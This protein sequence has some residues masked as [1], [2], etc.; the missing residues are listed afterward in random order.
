MEHR[1]FYLEALLTP[2]MTCDCSI[3]GGSPAQ[4]CSVEHFGGPL[5]MHVNIRLVESRYRRK[6]KEPISGLSA[7]PPNQASHLPM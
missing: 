6:G 3:M 2:Q 7:C 1:F 5:L 4:G